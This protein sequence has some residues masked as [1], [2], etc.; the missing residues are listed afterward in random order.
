M[1]L[2]LCDPMSTEILFME[3]RLVGGGMCCSMYVLN[4][5]YG[6]RYV[7]TQRC[8]EVEDSTPILSHRLPTIHEWTE[9]GNKIHHVRT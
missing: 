4:V 6:L 3:V 1:K 5:F 8:A 2:P 9:D 7:C